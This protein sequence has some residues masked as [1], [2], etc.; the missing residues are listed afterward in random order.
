MGI[1]I[2]HI[3]PYKLTKLLDHQRVSPYLAGRSLSE[4]YSSPLFS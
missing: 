3:F 1:L 4:A 2:F